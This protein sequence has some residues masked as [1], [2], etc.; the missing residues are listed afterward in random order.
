LQASKKITETGF[1][2]KYLKNDAKQP[3]SCLFTGLHPGP[4]VEEKPLCPFGAGEPEKL[5]HVEFGEETASG[6]ISWKK[7]KI[8]RILEELQRGDHIL[9]SELSRLGRSMLECMEILSISME[10][11]IHVDFTP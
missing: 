11:G 9:V 3:Y 10:K 2:S 8:G 4:G 7:R 1:S 5:G 6:K